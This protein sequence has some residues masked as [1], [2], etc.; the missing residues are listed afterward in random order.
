M[1]TKNRAILKN[2][3]L[4]GSVPK[5]NQF[6]DLIDSF[7]NQEDDGILKKQ[8]EAI[9]LKAEGVN[10]E[11]L[12]F[13]KNIEDFK[14]TWS[15][16]Q[17]ASDGNDGFNIA[18]GGEISRLF[19]ENGGNVGIG[20]TQ[21]KA[22]LDVDGFVSMKGRV[23]SYAE[24]QVPADGKWHDVVNQLN[25][26][27]AFELIAVVGVKGAH[28]ITHAIAVSSYGGSK[29][30]ITKTRGFYGFRRNRIDIRWTGS[31]FD[32]QLQVR[33]MRNLGEGVFIKFNLAKLF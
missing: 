23:G 18:E 16:S 19:I 22:K 10:E 11:I 31:Y 20:I 30:D 9:K 29:G 2:Y 3:F 26:Y 24:G 8:G 7:I 12:A 32:Y 1:A 4:K 17:V 33:T 6:Q 28:A 5:E 14:P 25:T 15:I 13:F 27:N 21:P